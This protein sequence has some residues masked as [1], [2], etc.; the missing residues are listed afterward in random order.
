MLG[1]APGGGGT[2][3]GRSYCAV[4]VAATAGDVLATV[5]L[6]STM[7]SVGDGAAAAARTMTVLVEVA[8]RPD[9]S[10]TT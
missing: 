1:V 5:G 4:L 6:D 3:L 7:T 8:V 2:A 9:W 10:V